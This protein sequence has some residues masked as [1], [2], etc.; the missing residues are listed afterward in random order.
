[1]DRGFQNLLKLSESQTLLA[2][3][4]RDFWNPKISGL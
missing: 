2:A 4:G 3:S 1:M